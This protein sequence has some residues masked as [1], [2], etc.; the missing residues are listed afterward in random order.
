[1]AIWVVTAFSSATFIGVQMVNRTRRLHSGM[2]HAMLRIAVEQ[3]L[4]CVGVGG[5][6]SLVIERSVPAAAWMLPGLWQ[7][8][9]SLGV[10]ASCRFLPRAILAA[11]LWYLTTGLTCLSLGGLRAL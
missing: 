6:V 1:M 11:G 4:P 7:V 2:A 9:F 3:F 5:L 10:F 8:I